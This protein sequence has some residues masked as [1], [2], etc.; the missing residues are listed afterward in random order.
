MERFVFP[1]E[2]R[3]KAALDQMNKLIEWYGVASRADMMDIH[4]T[5]PSPEDQKF[6]WNDLS[7][8]Y[9]ESDV[10]ALEFVLVLPRA[11]RLE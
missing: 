9:I 1:D 8:A 3:A 4:G 10:R 7:N 11:L 6:G 2:G 5:T